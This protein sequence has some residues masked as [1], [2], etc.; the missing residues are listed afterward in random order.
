MQSFLQFGADKNAALAF[1][2]YDTP[3]QEYGLLLRLWPAGLRGGGGDILSYGRMFSFHAPSV[4]GWQS[5][6][7]TSVVSTLQFLASKDYT[8]IQKLVPCQ[9]F[10]TG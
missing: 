9:P 7:I 4:L 2:Q 3:K 1:L 5:A 8:W 6:I 10:L